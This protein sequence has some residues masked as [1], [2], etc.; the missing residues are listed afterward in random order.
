MGAKIA[1]KDIPITNFLI[2]IFFQWSIKIQVTATTLSNNL[3][4]IGIWAFE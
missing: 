4:L 2:E 3:A 1:P